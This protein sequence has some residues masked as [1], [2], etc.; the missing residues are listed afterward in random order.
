MFRL[1]LLSIHWKHTD[2]VDILGKLIF[3]VACC[4]QA[5]TVAP[6]S[7]KSSEFTVSLHFTPRK[8]RVQLSLGG[9]RALPVG[10]SFFKNIY[11]TIERDSR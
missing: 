9:D 8:G 5:L 11:F 2:L 4:L 10:S 3:E 7:E 6:F 1:F